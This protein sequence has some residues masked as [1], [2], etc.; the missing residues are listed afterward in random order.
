MD[1]RWEKTNYSVLH[2]PEIPSLDN[3][4]SERERSL[5]SF[6]SRYGSK[7]VVSYLLICIDRS[8]PNGLAWCWGLAALRWAKNCAK[9]KRAKGIVSRREF[10]IKTMADGNK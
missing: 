2:G 1:R 6:V 9:G 8:L 10:T 7:V 3:D 4:Q 5:S